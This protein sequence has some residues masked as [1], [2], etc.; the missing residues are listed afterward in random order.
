MSTYYLRFE[1]EPDRHIGLLED[2]TVERFKAKFAEAKA[3]LGCLVIMACHSWKFAEAVT[4]YVDFVVAID[5]DKKVDNKAA[6]TFSEQFYESL[7]SGNSY[8]ESFDKAQKY[9]FNSF[10]PCSCD[11][12]QPG[13]NR[14]YPCRGRHQVVKCDCPELKVNKHL[15]NCTGSNDFASTLMEDEQDED[16]RWLCCCGCS[17]RERYHAGYI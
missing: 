6:E 11:A 12:R 16:Y 14:D 2:I 1:R 17:H 5:Q 10:N 9:I 13:C 15:K 4:D 8:E 7:I 3:K